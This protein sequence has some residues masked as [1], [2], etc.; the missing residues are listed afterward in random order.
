VDNVDQVITPPDFFSLM[1]LI[2]LSITWSA[3]GK[4]LEIAVGIVA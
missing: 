2:A 3:F 1:V 4:R